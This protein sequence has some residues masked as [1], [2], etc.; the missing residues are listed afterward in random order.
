[1]RYQKIPFVNSPILNGLTPMCGYGPQYPNSSMLGA[2]SMSRFFG[3]EAASNDNGLINQTDMLFRTRSRKP[4]GLGSMGGL[5]A[6]PVKVLLRPQAN[7]PAGF[8]GFFAWLKATQPAMW[9]Y[10]KVALP[11]YQTQ[12]EGHRTG[13]ATLMGLGA[14]MGAIDNWLATRD[15]LTQLHGLGDDTTDSTPTSFVDTSTFAAPTIDVPLPTVNIPDTSA[16]TASIGTPPNP[17]PGAVA[18]IISTLAAAAPQILSTVNQQTMF[19]TQL[20]RA[21]AG[22]PPLNTA[23]FGLTSALSS[24][25][26]LPI[27]IGVAAIAAFMMLRKRR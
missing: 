2:T 9:N 4:Y 11:A 27:G 14:Y 12:A 3:E 16:E 7:T 1:M 17:G 5:G 23:A 21:K 15:T 20:S 6:A 10:A 8:P 26:I 19:N 24:S 22:L 25:A 18:Q 13:G